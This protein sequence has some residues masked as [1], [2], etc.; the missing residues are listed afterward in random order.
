[1]KPT[2]YIGTTGKKLYYPNV[3]FH[4]MVT[5]IFAIPDGYK[6]VPIEPTEEMTSAGRST[7][8]YVLDT[9]K[10]MIEAAP[11]LEDMP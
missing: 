2:A 7:N 1:M 11:K 4:E 5:P 10:A 3:S 9:Y 6:L 8:L